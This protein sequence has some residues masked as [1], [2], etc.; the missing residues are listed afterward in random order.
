MLCLPAVC[1]KPW[2]RGQRWRREELGVI[3]RA[4]EVTLFESFCT[5]F[6]IFKMGLCF[7]YFVIVRL[8]HQS[9]LNP[10]CVPGPVLRR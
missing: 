1:Q 3:K 8:E 2:S 9:F 4:P 7:L 10:C 5:C 6:L